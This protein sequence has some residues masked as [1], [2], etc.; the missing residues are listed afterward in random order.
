MK[1]RVREISLR[2]ELLF[3]VFQINI[4]KKNQSYY[5]KKKRYNQWD[6]LFM[7]NLCFNSMQKKR[8][9]VVL[10]IVIVLILFLQIFHPFLIMNSK[11]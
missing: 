1:K 6:T 7:Y 8:G 9:I 5:F 2:F 4:K 3:F 10:F 11:Y